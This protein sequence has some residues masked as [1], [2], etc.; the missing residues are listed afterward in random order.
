MTK[1]VAPRDVGFIPDGN[2]RWSMGH[3]LPQQAGSAHGINPVLLL[4]E[5][6]VVMKGFVK[7]VMKGFVKDIEGLRHQ[8]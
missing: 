1:W 3:G 7:D 5:E 6:G 8:E 2:R 4:C